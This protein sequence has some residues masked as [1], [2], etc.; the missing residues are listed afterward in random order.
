MLINRHYL[1]V[2]T[3]ST[4]LLGLPLQLQDLLVESLLLRG[5]DL[6]SLDVHFYEV[7]PENVLFGILQVTLSQFTSTRPFK[8]ITPPDVKPRGTGTS[9]FPLSVWI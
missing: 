6:R 4:L 8:D 2:Y 3:L 1:R 5:E 9:I 7:V